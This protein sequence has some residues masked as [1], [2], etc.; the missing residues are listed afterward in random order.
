MPPLA[1]AISFF[2][3]RYADLLWK[4]SEFVLDNIRAEPKCVR[5][6]TS[7]PRQPLRCQL[8]RN[9]INHELPV[10]RCRGHFE[11]EG[12]YALR[13]VVSD[14]HDGCTHS[15]EIAGDGDIL[16]AHVPTVNP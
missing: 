8:N 6:D 14:N 1:N 16:L 2:L 15:R 12:R 9:Y 4:E 7:P 11:R 13:Q 3:L 10:R 5:V